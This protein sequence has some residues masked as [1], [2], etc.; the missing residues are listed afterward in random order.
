MVLACITE[1]VVTVIFVRPVLC[2]E[3]AR[4]PPTGYSCS[5]RTRT[6][7][8]T[9]PGFSCPRLSLSGRPFL[10]R[11]RACTGYPP[12]Q[13]ERPRLQGCGSQLDQS[14]WLAQ[15]QGIRRGREVRKSPPLLQLPQSAK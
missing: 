13:P 11:P 7:P 12:Q 1:A 9:A 6:T 2:L 10:P 5:L 14:V 8:G 15:G 3:R 4:A